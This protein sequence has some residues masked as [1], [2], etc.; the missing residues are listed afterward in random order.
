MKLRRSPSTTS[1]A[2]GE[3]I[4]LGSTPSQ[5]TSAIPS[6]DE[7]TPANT[8]H[9]RWALEHPIREETDPTLYQQHD[10]AHISASHGHRR[11]DERSESSQIASTA[12]GATCSS[13][14]PGGE[15]LRGLDITTPAI[16]NLTSEVEECLAR[17]PRVSSFRTDQHVEMV[18]WLSNQV[19][20]GRNSSFHGLSGQD[21]EELG[22]I[23]Y[24]SLKI[25][26]KILIGKLQCKLLRSACVLF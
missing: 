13:R 19:T 23:E 15:V 17:H 25:L 21:R 2:T 7:L 18:P 1:Q 16:G 24:R 11:D 5:N 12:H 9:I 14:D 3:D 26:L 4:E 22:G 20:I 6:P 10:L 8:G